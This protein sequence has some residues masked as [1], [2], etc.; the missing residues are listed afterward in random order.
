MGIKCE[1]KGCDK[2]QVGCHVTCESY[3]EFCDKKR[4]IRERDA[5]E[6]YTNFMIT[7]MK[8]QSIRRTK[9]R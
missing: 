2:R 9:G 8:K 5:K 7:D 4:E 6:R 3:K 1:C